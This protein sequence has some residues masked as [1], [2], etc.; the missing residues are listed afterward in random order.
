MITIKEIIT[1]ALGEASMLFMSQEK[2][3]TEIVMP[4]EELS[5]IVD[6][7]AE[8]IDNL[9]ETA[10]GIIC[11]VSQGDWTKQNKEWQETV[12]KFRTEYFGTEN[13]DN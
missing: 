3:G 9:L 13:Q 10:W 5:K 2:K 4:T 8:P 6:K 7:T 1:Q 12:A 11:N